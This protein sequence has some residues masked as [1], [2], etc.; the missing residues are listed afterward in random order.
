MVSPTLFQCKCIQGLIQTHFYLFKETE[1]KMLSLTAAKCLRY[2]YINMKKDIF[3]VQVQSTTLV[4]AGVA[5]IHAMFHSEMGLAM[6]LSS[7][8]FKRI[9]FLLSP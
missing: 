7:T 6:K 4:S 8:S 3:R 9:N 1:L 5:T 2:R